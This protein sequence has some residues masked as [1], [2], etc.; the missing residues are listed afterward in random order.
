MISFKPRLERRKYISSQRSG[1]TATPGLQSLMTRQS[2]RVLFKTLPQSTVILPRFLPIGVYAPLEES[3]KRIVYY[4]VPNDLRID[5]DYIESLDLDPADTIFYYIHQF[6]MHI[7]E[8]VRVAQKMRE[9]GFFVVDDRSLTLPVSTYR[10][11]GDATAYSFYKLVGIPYGGEIRTEHSA[12]TARQPSALRMD[13]SHKQLM[14]KMR[15]NFLFFATPF[16]D[17]LPAFPYRVYNRLFS[18]FICYS[19]LIEQT[20]TD[21][22]PQM[23]THHTRKLSNI[24]FDAVTQRR[25][26]IAGM[27]FDELDPSFLLPVQRE[28]V[29]TQSM[30][31]FPILVADPM[32]TLKI[33]V[34]RGVT[35][36]RF[37]KIWWWDKSREPC[38]LYNRNLLLPAHHHLSNKDVRKIIDVVNTA[39]KQH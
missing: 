27:Y 25:A 21:I 38:D 22:L 7:P 32:A 16:V 6:G 35:T 14:Q 31:G 1:H 36:F 26:E 17:V 23:P 24:N 10:E 15:N 2:L 3:G 11:F 4:D 33:L 28:A 19:H 39:C 30:M 12:T 9:R 34:R 8:N 37:T 13:D 5:S 20:L 29:T 18:R